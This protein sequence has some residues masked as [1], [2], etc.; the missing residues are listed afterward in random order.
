MA[1][2]VPPLALLLGLSL[3]VVALRRLKG[4]VPVGVEA[5]AITDDERGRLDAALA[6]LE[7]LEE[8]QS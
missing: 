2:L 3:V 1:W 4:P 6:E 8:A 5:D 7:E